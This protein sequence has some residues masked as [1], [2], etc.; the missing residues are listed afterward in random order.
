MN[1]SENLAEKAAEDIIAATPSAV[2]NVNKFTKEIFHTRGGRIGSGMGSVV[3]ALWGFH[4]NKLLHSSEYELG[5]IYGHEYNDFACILSSE[6]WEPSTKAGELLRV[7]VKSMV[8]S[9]DESKAHFD[10]LLHEFDRNELLAVFLWDWTLVSEKN[11]MVYPAI[12][13]Y[14][15]GLA[16]PVARLRDELHLGR[17]GTFVSA[18][19]C[20]DKCGAQCTHIGEPLNAAGVRERRSGPAKAKGPNVSYAANFGGLLRMLGSRGSG[21]REILRKHYKSDPTTARFLDFMSRNFPRVAKS[22]S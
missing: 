3:E 18:E 20:P 2:Q 21:G 17:G 13:D 14:F 4:T 1:P 19:S 16:I 15:V 6:L 5:W 10:R 11:K 12:L 9:A 22:M 8:A 7:E